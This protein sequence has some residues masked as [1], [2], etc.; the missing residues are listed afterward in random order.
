MH[1]E[2]EY[3]F[4]DQLESAGEKGPRYYFIKQPENCTV[5]FAFATLVSCAHSLMYTSQRF[6]CL[7]RN[8]YIKLTSSPGNKRKINALFNTIK[9]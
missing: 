5:F 3:G 2:R 6:T 8:I 4:V 7:Q 9:L 1:R